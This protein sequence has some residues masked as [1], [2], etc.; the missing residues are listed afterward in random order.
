MSSDPSPSYPM[1]SYPK[2]SNSWARVCPRV[3][4]APRVCTCQCCGEMFSQS[5]CEISGTSTS[6]PPTPPP[7][8][9]PINTPRLMSTTCLW[10]RGVSAEL[11]RHA[12]QHGVHA[13]TSGPDNCDVIK[14]TVIIMMIKNKKKKVRMISS[15]DS[16][17][18]NSYL[19]LITVYARAKRKQTGRQEAKWRSV[20]PAES[21]SC[22]LSERSSASRHFV[23]STVSPQVRRQRSVVVFFLFKN[24]LGC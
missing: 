13:L 9:A 6:S 7:P 17:A 3:V 18:S 24:F 5:R 1:S 19:T 2:K 10:C 23:G 11:C 12:C 15:R 22:G 4:R 20:S 14:E 16:H 21:G 8:P